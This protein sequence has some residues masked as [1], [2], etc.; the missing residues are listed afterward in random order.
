VLAVQ[1][2]HDLSGFGAVDGDTQGAVGERGEDEV[3]P[4]AG[5]GGGEAEAAIAE[6]ADA[7]AVERLQVDTSGP[8]LTQGTT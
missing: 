2:E 8:A 4:A 5:L 7:A 1:P 6:Q 3:E